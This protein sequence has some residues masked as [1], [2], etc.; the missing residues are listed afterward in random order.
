MSLLLPRKTLYVAAILSSSLLA[1]CSDSGSSNADDVVETIASGS[2]DS[3]GVDTDAENSTTDGGDGSTTE[4]TNETGTV[5]DTEETPT[6]VEDTETGNESGNENP[7]ATE[8]PTEGSSGESTTGSEGGGVSEEAEQVTDSEPVDFPNNPD[9]GLAPV[10]VTGSDLSGSDDD[11]PTATE[12]ASISAPFLKDANRPNGPPSAPEGLTLLMSGENF[13]EMTWEPSTD[14]QSVEAYEIYRDGTMVYKIN[15]D[16]TYTFDYRS[17]LSTSYMDCDYTHYDCSKNP[18]TPG[19][20][21]SYQVAAID[22]EGARSELS[23]PVVFKMAQS[24]RSGP[25]LTGYSLVFDEEFEADVLDRTFWKTS[26]PWGEN[27]IVNRESQY[28]VNLFGADPLPVNPFVMTGTTLQITGTVTPPDLLERANNQ[29]YLSGVITTK[30]KFQMTY[31]YVEMNAKL[32]SGTGLLSTFF[33]FN[34]D[35]EKNK[36]EIDIM[37]YDGGKP[38]IANQTYHYHDS[39]RHRRGDGERHSTPTMKTDVNEL[40]SDFHTFSVLWEPELIIWYIDGTEVRRLEGV[41]VSDEPMNIVSQLVIGSEWIGD[42][43][44]SALPAVL[45]IDYIKAWQKQ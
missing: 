1:A 32:A 18:V 14:D 35:F 24:E 40:S 12:S 13:I 7:D 15:F 28:F 9:T 19:S 31:G 4:T 5:P 21:Y 25:D 37:E 20:S 11:S 2:I 22:N 26:L 16:S 17:W 6:G 33:L 36:P 44:P 42:P 23:Q 43:D 10:S 27:E 34:Q 39:V 30:D 45:E 38:T 29:P 41:R 3:N 8:S